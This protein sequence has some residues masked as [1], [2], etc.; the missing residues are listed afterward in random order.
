M[1]LPLE[2]RRI[3]E[4][5]ERA[6]AAG[7][8]KRALEL[9]NE[10]LALAME[11]LP[12]QPALR[13]TIESYLRRAMKL[14]PAELPAAEP[15]PEA[16][17]E[18]G[19]RC[20]VT[21][22]ERGR[23]ARHVGT[24]AF[25]GPT[26]LGEGLWIGVMLDEPAKGRHDGLVQGVRY[27]RCPAERGLLVRAGRA[28]RLVGAPSPQQPSSARRGSSAS[29]AASTS[30]AHNARV[31]LAAEERGRQ[32]HTSPRQE[33]QRR[34]GSVGSAS[35]RSSATR[36]EHSTLRPGLAVGGGSPPRWGSPLS[37]RSHAHPEEPETCA[38]TSHR[39]D[40]CPAVELEDEVSRL[41]AELRA[42]EKQ[43][44]NVLREREEMAEALAVR[45]QPA[46]PCMLCGPVEAEGWPCG[47]MVA[48]GSGCAVVGDQRAR[49]RR[50]VTT[51][52][53]L[54]PHLTSCLPHN[55]GHRALWIAA[56]AAVGWGVRAQG[57]RKSCG[58][59]TSPSR[60]NAI[61]SGSTT[62]TVSAGCS[63]S[64]NVLSIRFVV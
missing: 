14:Q 61:A 4:Q 2:A 22:H 60:A 11:L 3:V 53:S 5:A 52:H 43:L 25:V 19:E 64:R 26:V 50:R 44:Q 42:A 33:R 35:F 38:N 36:H 8:N 41:E 13:T 9:Y 39:V 6:E 48:G 10:G 28:T 30:A 34:R 23:S 21:T 16:E 40:D 37:S 24:V 20:R 58:G 45:T 31:A 7:R 54:K 1:E 15:E 46:A 59:P 56:A 32:R 27:F 57:A 49:R 51:T 17:L 62:T 55:I 47:R 12:E 18:K 63:R 29:S